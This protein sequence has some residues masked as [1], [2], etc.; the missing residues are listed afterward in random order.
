[1]PVIEFI[2]S[3]PDPSTVD[4]ADHHPINPARF[5]AA[6]EALPLDALHSK[7][8]EIRNS[9]A[10]LRRSNEQMLPFADEGDQDCKD[11][12][13]ENLTVIGRMNGRVQMLKTE[14][15]RRG[16]VW[17]GDDGVTTGGQLGRSA[18]EE[19][20][21]VVVDRNGNVSSN[22]VADLADASAVARS[23]SGRL[24]D[25]ELRRQMEA[26]T[27]MNGEGETEEDGVHL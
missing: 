11:A 4:P 27:G 23:Q 7:A 18:V 14:V 8:A 25:E 13:F 15:E 19:G 24:T 26:R 17:V 3:A 20:G 5:A 2:P 10:H 16:M 21:V 9:I 1:M 12:M 22:G 6:L